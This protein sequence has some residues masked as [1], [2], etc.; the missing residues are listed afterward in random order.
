MNDYY[1]NPSWF[2]W[3]NVADNLRMVLIISLILIASGTVIGV[4]IL[5]EAC[6]DEISYKKLLKK[7]IIILCICIAGLVFIPSKDTCIEMIV[8]QTVT[9]A[10]VNYAK[11]EVKD[12]IDYVFDKINEVDSEEQK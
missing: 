10:N 12:V 1:I 6:G 3:I 11:G 4:P 9:P 5:S 8:A 2:Y 7:C